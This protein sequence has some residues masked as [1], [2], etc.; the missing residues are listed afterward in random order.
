MADPKIKFKRSSVQG[1]QPGAADLPLGELAL[2]TYDGRAYISKS[3]DGGISTSVVN[4]SGVQVADEGTNVGYAN[5]LNFV[6]SG[7]SVSVTNGVSVVNITS[8]GSVGIATTLSASIE[9]DTF[10]VGVGGQSVFNST[11]DYASGYINV[12][13]NGVKLTTSD[14][15]ESGT[16]EI[17]LNSAASQGDI[18]ELENFRTI[19]NLVY[20][21]P[22][23]IERDSFIVGPGGQS[24][25]SS[26]SRYSSGHLNVYLNGVK[27]NS[28]DFVESASNQITLNVAAS[29]GDIVELE[30]FKTISLI[31]T[32]SAVPSL[33][34]KLLDDISSSFNGITTTFV[35]T[36]SSQSVSPIAKNSIINIGGIQQ[37]PNIDYSISGGNIT[38]TTPP[39][40]GLTFSGRF[41]VDNGYISVLANSG[42]EVKQSGVSVG[43]GITQINF[44]SGASITPA[45]SGVTTVTVTA[46]GIGSALS[47]DSSKLSN[48]VYKTQFT[49]TVA[50]GTSETIDVENE[51][52]NIAFTLLGQIIVGSGATLRIGTGTTMIMNV[53]NIF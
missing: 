10:L 30:N 42:L 32:A 45:S 37:V 49:R 6:G 40:A 1:K 5:T 2:N 12:Y 28:S 35:L 52:G 41:F 16:A 23:Q 25:F 44:A 33:D 7:V 14:F 11:S 27:L 26:N 20:N 22:S 19:A 48:V 36:S 39:D 34:I 43:T 29:Q 38:F 3:T 13:L 17:T 50:T 53:L 18:V 24:V 9:K 8:G 51:Y 31:D 46:A 4:L 47:S 21:P 15:T